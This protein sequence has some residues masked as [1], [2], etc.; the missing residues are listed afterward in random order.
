M[1][2][3][4]CCLLLGSASEHVLM[5]VLMHERPTGKVAPQELRACQVKEQW[6]MR[7]LVP[8]ADSMTELLHVPWVVMRH[9]SQGHLPMQFCS[10]SHE[11]STQP[12]NEQ[13]KVSMN[14]QH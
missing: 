2:E 10:H 7:H 12:Y 13:R 8:H 9:N 5:N 6:A 1:L 11:H 3:S 14:G 4:L